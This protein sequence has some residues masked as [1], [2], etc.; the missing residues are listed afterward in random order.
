MDMKHIVN[1][2]FSAFERKDGEAWV[3]LFASDGSL[4]G[5]AHTPPVMGHAAL[6]ELFAGIAMLFE[7]IHFDI[8]AV[9]VHGPFAVAE[10]DLHTRARNGRT[11]Q[12]QGMVAFAADDAGKLTQVA[13]FWDP[14]PVFSQ[15]MAA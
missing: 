3:S 12:A 4:G 14:A 5:P 7:T 15:A 8:L 9:H 11:P 6:A 1:A 2:Y 13:G 10:F